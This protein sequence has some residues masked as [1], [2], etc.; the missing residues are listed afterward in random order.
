MLNIKYSRGYFKRQ[1]A[2]IFNKLMRFLKKEKPNY[3]FFT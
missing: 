1:D 2:K 3:L